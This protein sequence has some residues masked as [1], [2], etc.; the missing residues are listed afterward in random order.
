[1]STQLARLQAAPAR[2]E[3]RKVSR[4]PAEVTARMSSVHGDEA[5]VRLSDVSTHGCSIRGEA[6]WLRTG[7][8][9]AIGFGEEADLHA[10]VRWVR[11]GSAGMEFLRP[12]PSDRREWHALIDSPLG[13]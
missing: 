1:M 5:Y 2:Q 8:F 3:R 12:V 6:E 11:E 7:A 10:V 13:N 9:V 4:T